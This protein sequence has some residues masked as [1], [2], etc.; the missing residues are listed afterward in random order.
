MNR[1]IIILILIF[2]F[3]PALYAQRQTGDEFAA[4]IAKNAYDLTI[5]GDFDESLALLNT[6]L[7]RCDGFE[8][9][10]SCRSIIYFNT[11]YLYERRFQTDMDTAWLD[12]AQA[13][14]DR[15]LTDFPSD[16]R[17]LERNAELLIARNDFDQANG[18][19]MRLMEL[20]PNERYRY[21]LMNSK[22]LAMKGETYSS[23]QEIQKALE[24]NPFEEA[25][26]RALVNL[27]AHENR[28]QTIVNVREYAYDCSGYGYQALALEVLQNFMINNRNEEDAQIA[29]M[30]WAN[31]LTEHNL[32]TP[33]R[34][35]FIP[36]PLQWPSEANIQLQLLFH[37]DTLSDP[38]GVVD[39][40][41]FWNSGL[42][43]DDD[44]LS[45]RPFEVLA[46]IM[47]S[48][49]DKYRTKNDAARA[50]LFYNLALDIVN[51]H[52]PDDF[53][54][55][56][57]YFET[58]G[59][60]AEIYFHHPELD[61][62]EAEYT[63][64][65]RELFVGK[66]NAYGSHSFDVIKKYHITLGIIYARK[67]IWNTPGADNARFQLERAIR[68]K[69]EYEYLPYIH[70]LL[71]K[72]FMN[73][74][75]QKER[76]FR[77]AL[78]AAK[79]YLMVDDLE[80]AET[81]L[82]LAQTLNGSASRD[83]LAQALAYRELAKIRRGISSDSLKIGSRAF[84]ERIEQWETMIGRMN[85]DP[86]FRDFQKFKIFSAAGRLAKGKGNVNVKIT[87]YQKALS[88]LKD[89]SSLPGYT[90]LIGLQRIKDF[91]MQE[92]KFTDPAILEIGRVSLKN[93]SSRINSDKRDYRLY[94]DDAD[95]YN[96]SIDPSLFQA[97]ELAA[98]FTKNSQRIPEITIGSNHV[99]V[100][101]KNLSERRKPAIEND[102]KEI[103]KGKIVRVE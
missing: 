79:E 73:D 34:L 100:K 54:I 37:F 17:A 80:S 21:L 93:E 52:H 70:S 99:I 23:L 12:R 25:G 59:V 64:L 20:Y 19:I 103:V 86:K 44:Y 42:R 87:C 2:S 5:N 67:G 96:I 24:I 18:A 31:L 46:K 48:F 89:R 102:V 81:H 98:Y 55:P 22:A 41:S 32:F 95:I 63:K 6:G 16:K 91:L 82:D 49:G 74:P 60:L 13:Y 78:D 94:V 1:S 88:A 27:Y 26:W 97:V 45:V 83:Q 69:S 7:N 51:S 40:L 62:G 77:A 15:I 28:Y 43:I 92:V 58:A 39:E 35:D 50:K 47:R 71:A 10:K 61:P 30:H 4:K 85:L 53:E 90:D 29:L 14:Y 84:V 76:A 72:G 68:F 75:D 57:V 56:I 11:A 38:A 66:N 65:T 33:N 8:N 9:A 101:E 36:S 3:W